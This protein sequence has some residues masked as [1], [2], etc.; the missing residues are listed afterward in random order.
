MFFKQ[1][2]QAVMASDFAISQFRFLRH[3][4]LIH[5]RYNYRRLS[6]LVLYSFYKNMAF[7]LC[8]FWFAFDSMFSAENLYDAYAMAAF[9]LAFTTVKQCLFIKS[10]RF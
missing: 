2:Q 3:L 1:G 5:G 10:L 8:Q 9:N 6:K 4:I 7:V